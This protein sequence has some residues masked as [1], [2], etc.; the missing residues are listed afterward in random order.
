MADLRQEG[1][2][3]IK[4]TEIG[5]T[6]GNTVASV[7]R[8]VAPTD[9]FIDIEGSL[10][11]TTK[12]SNAGVRARADL[13]RKGQPPQE[14]GTWKAA[15]AAVATNLTHIEVRKGDTIDFAV[16][17]GGSAQENYTWAPFLRLTDSSGDLPPK[18][19]WNAQSEFAG[20][21]PAPPKGMTPWEK[22]A[23]TLLLT[24]EFVYV[25]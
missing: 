23:Q 17:S 24:N 11:T 18:H 16:L 21:P 10:A 5:G 2:R 13:Q 1:S 25:N 19:D 8:W 3:K 7:R 22:Y 14:L 20:P 6:T 9:G 15:K 4:V 12:N